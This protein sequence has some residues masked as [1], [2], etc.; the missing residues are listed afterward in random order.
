[1]LVSPLFSA[2]HS[3]GDGIYSTLWGDGL[4][5]GVSDLDSGPP[6]NYDLMGAGY[7]ISLG[8]SLLLILGAALA[9]A[10]LTR[11][12]RA[13][14]LL[15]SGILLVFGFGLVWNTLQ[16]P[17]YCAVKAFYAFP[18]LL[19]FSALVAVGWDWL[20]QRRRGIGVAV[21]VLLLVW[22][23]TVY[24]AFWVRSGNP[25]TQMLKCV[26]RG[27]ALMARGK[28]DE[29]IRQFQEASR[30]KPESASAHNNLGVALGK[31]G[32]TD[33]AIRQYQEAI[34]VKPGHA[35]ARS[36]LGNALAKEGR[37]EEAIHQF[38][39]AIRVRPDLAEAHNG[40]GVVFYQQG[41]VGE[42]IRQFQEV[43]RLEPD[44][45]DAHYDLGV[46]FYQQGRVAEA[47]RQFQEVIRLKPDH[48][49]AHNNLGTVFGRS[50]QTDEAIHQFQ[51]AL[52]F[53]PDYA[54]ARRNL[55]ILLAPRPII[56]LR[57]VAP[58]SRKLIGS[59]LC[60]NQRPRECR[61]QKAEDRRQKCRSRRRP[62]PL[63]LNRKS[64]IANRKSPGG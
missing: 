2:F 23:M 55:D 40:L 20:R 7:W 28:L 17:Y 32:R 14:W 12:V 9:L 49:E 48:A 42:A 3:F 6:W 46:A 36:N 31:A 4:A 41:R 1:M 33:E 52:R 35:K 57:P 56:R 58:P 11:R 24:A 34:R 10:R 50:G 22:S 13:E 62:Q 27:S 53:K 64:E 47:A 15:M 19:P 5:S 25:Q 43:I 60:A 61:R 21:W 29:A 38:Q 26:E 45:T 51:Q 39:E 63:P 59:V 37:T 18:A 16:A 54:D 8:V 44:D 30:L